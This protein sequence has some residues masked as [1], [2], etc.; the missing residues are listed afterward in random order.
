MTFFMSTG[1]VLS[2]NR[3]VGKLVNDCF[4]AVLHKKLCSAE[5]AD[6]YLKNNNLIDLRNNFAIK[7]KYS[8]IF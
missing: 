2:R 7:G 8:G 1:A 6:A 5:N 4:V 3:P